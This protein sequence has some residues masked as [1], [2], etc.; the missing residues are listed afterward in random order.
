MRDHDTDPLH[1]D[2]GLNFDS[3]FDSTSNDGNTK[4]R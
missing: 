4:G 2:F 1:P 3:D